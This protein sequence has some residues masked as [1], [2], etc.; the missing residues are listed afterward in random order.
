[1][2]GKE[3]IQT[4]YTYND[5]A[6]QRLFDAAEKVGEAELKR[7]ALEGQRDL[8]ELLFHIIRTEWVWRILIQTQ[9][10]PTNP[11]ELAEM[12]TLAKLSA[13]AQAEVH[14]RQ[15]LLAQLKDDELMT[16]LQVQQRNG[17]NA[18]MVL[19]HMLMQPV[20]HGVQHRS[21]AAL[22]LTSLGQSPGDIDF[23]FFV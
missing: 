1:M 20:I 23:I 6:N 16:P 21:E 15:A 8:H 12:N 14:E 5:W 10:R 3:I 18:P 4:L 22:I 13:F 7:T 11:P 2:P 17:Q 19:W 9:A